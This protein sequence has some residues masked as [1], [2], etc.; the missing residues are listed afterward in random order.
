MNGLDFKVS[1]EW[2]GTFLLAGLPDDYRPMIMGLESSGTPITAD[3]IKTKL[4]QSEM[5]KNGK[6][7]LFSKGKKLQNVSNA[8]K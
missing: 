7:A 4:L 2:V 3:S 5:S 8:R 1:D 6:S